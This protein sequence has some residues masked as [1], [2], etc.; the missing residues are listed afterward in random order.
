MTRRC[1]PLFV[2]LLLSILC[3]YHT[4]KAQRVKTQTTEQKGSPTIQR[5]DERSTVTAQDETYQLREQKAPLAVL[6]RLK[7]LR[8][9]ILTQKLPYT[10]GFTSASERGLGLLAGTKAPDDLLTS[11]ERQDR[12]ARELLTID[13]KAVEDHFAKNNL[14]LPEYEREVRV[15]APKA[16][17]WRDENKVTAIRD[18]QDCGSCWDFATIGAYESAYLLRNGI[19]IDASEQCV[20]DCS[21]AGSCRGGWWAFDFLIT[22]GTAEENDY[23]Y[24][25]KERDCNKEIKKPYRAVAWNYVEVRNR[26]PDRERIKSAI[27]KYG[28]VAAAVQATDRFRYYTGGVFVDVPT[29]SEPDKQQQNVNHGVTIV[30]WDDGKWKAGAWLIKNS[31]GTEWGEKGYMWIAYDNNCIGYGSAWVKPQN[32]DVGLTEKFLEFVKRMSRP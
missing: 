26:V 3:S 15:A 10:V 4:G 32:K 30:G 7:E 27:L 13:S 1:I 20:L 23:P 18:Q 24:K 22:N 31:W 29:P 2:V 16:F 11:A 21:N 5:S 6:E 28:P 19:K 12:I 9:E 25:G 8:Q 17:N 14:P